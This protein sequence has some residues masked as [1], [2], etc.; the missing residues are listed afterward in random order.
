MAWMTAALAFAVA[1][2]GAAEPKRPTKDECVEAY[3]KNQSL[4]RDGRY[5]EAIEQLLVCARDPCPA[6]LQTDCTSWLR[7]ARSLAPSIVV[8]PRAP[9]EAD[10]TDVRVSMD[11]VEVAS[12]LDGRPIEVDVGS[13]TFAFER[14]GSP[15]IE[16]KLLVVQ[17]EQNRIVDVDFTPPAPAPA[18]P[19]A[20]APSTPASAPETDAPQRP[21]PW[22]VYA[23][24]G[25]GAIALGTSAV[26]GLIGLSA[27]QD[28]YRCK[29]AGCPD[30]D[31]DAVA[32]KF[33]VADIALAAGVVLAGAAAIVYV[34]RPTSAPVST[35][36]IHASSVGWGLGATYSF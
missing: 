13:H 16:K 29:D 8:R 21:I 7:E 20:T 4:R 3:K 19:P 9:G 23:L 2:P 28:L 5:R 34:T 32:R 30:A 31:V 15:R 6:V 22:T 18:A 17:G 12:H 33:R 14:P 26:F 25:A 35:V 24:G 10:V 27:R 1:A 36:A 11:G